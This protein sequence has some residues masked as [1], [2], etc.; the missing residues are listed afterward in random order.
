MDNC[1][2]R[3]V[4]AAL[5]TRVVETDILVKDGVI[6]RIARN[7]SPREG[8]EEIEARG[9]YA[10]PGFVDI[11]CHGGRLFDATLGRYQPESDSFESSEQGYREGLMEFLESAESHG[12]TTQLLATAAAPPNELKRSLDI[13]GTH[14]ASEDNGRQGALL[15]GIFIEGSFIKN[16]EYAGA[17]NPEFF[18]TPSTQMFH[19]L[20][21]AAQGT[22]KY[23][24]IAPEH[25]EPAFE[26]IKHLK[27]R[28]V[29]VGAGHTEATGDQYARAVENG[30]RVAVHFTNGPTGGSYKPFN[31]GGAIEA[32][33]RTNDVF[34]ELITDAY[35]INPAYVMD[36]IARK[37]FE[38]IIVVTDSMFPTDSPGIDEFSLMGVKGKVSENGTHLRVAEKR[39]TLF[40]SVLTMDRAFSN[41][42]SWMTIEMPGVWR[43]KHYPLAFDIA[44]TRASRMLSENPAQAL[45]IFSPDS[46][47]LGEDPSVYTG[48]IEMGKRADILLADIKGEAGDYSLSVRETFIGGRRK[49]W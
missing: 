6:E 40:G 47:I 9:M 4:S 5:P 43:A 32:V 1:I 49:S 46:G 13:L 7:I 44:L 39:N 42:L 41:I 20:N 19:E 17:Q 29:L 18:N 3:G 38:R 15:A 10:L 28:N 24:N 21:N 33:L 34:A 2:I 31:G 22:I 27:D 23:V 30:L 37:G 35:H 25:E 12:T 45:G 11:H 36:I 8:F 48:S 14:C 16:P 26:L